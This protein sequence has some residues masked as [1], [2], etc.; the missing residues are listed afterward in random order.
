MTEA[1]LRIRCSQCSQAMSVPSALRGRA[2]RCKC[3]QNLKIPASAASGNASRRTCTACGKHLNVPA[4]LR[5][6]KVKCPCGQIIPPSSPGKAVPQVMTVKHFEVAKKMFGQLVVR[7]K[8]PTCSL[9]V[10]LEES[11][12]RSSHTCPECGVGFRL[13]K[14]ASAKLAEEK[15]KLSE[16]KQEKIE[17]K[18]A[19]KEEK[20]QARLAAL[21]DKAAK[22]ENA[23]LKQGNNSSATDASV[24]NFAADVVSPSPLQGLRT[25]GFTES[26]SM[27]GTG[28]WYC[29]QPT[30]Q[31][32]QCCYCRMLI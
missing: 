9:G 24:A 20:K 28:C 3:G 25:A 22:Q 12:C 27:H 2:V 5:T 19:L 8:C 23:R 29:G 26:F 16:K 21:K 15:Q 4:Q 13:P 14:A 11:E 31:S 17:A 1:K 6:K 30:Y 7:C 18:L 32:K 10:S